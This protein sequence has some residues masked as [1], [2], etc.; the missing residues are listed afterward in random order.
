MAEDVCVEYQ[1]GIVHVGRR[2]GTQAMVL[3][4][5]MSLIQ[6]WVIRAGQMMHCDPGM[7]HMLGSCHRWKP[8]GGCH[9]S[10]CDPSA[11]SRSPP[12]LLVRSDGVFM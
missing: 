10:G 6:L 9:C 11:A 8:T 1:A 2:W 7:C 12:V 4:L 5:P 3:L